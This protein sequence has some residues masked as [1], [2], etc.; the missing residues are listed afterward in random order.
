MMIPIPRAG[1]LVA[2]EG[3]EQA[4]AVEGIAG[5]EI[6]IAR[7]RPVV[8]RPDGD[9]YLGFM[10]ARAGSADAVERSLRAA[11]AR[12]RIAIEPHAPAPVGAR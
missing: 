10:F 7:G 9:R 2:V 5:L 11:H 4:R 12:L 3:Q 6:T 1:V 8:P